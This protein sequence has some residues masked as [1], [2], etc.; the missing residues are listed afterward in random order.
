MSQ[1]SCNA[2]NE[3]REYAPEF[4]VNG[5]T[6]AVCTHLANNKGLSNAD[7]HNDCDDLHDVNDCLIGN[8]A[9][10]LDAFDV[11]D[12]KDFLHQYI[13]NDY[14]TNKALICA[15]CGAWEMIESAWDKIDCLVKA[16]NS[17]VAGRSFSFDSNYVRFP[18]GV[19]AGSDPPFGFAGNAFCAY[20]TGGMMF[21]SNFYDTWLT[22][23]GDIPSG[24]GIL[25][26]E[27]RIPLCDSHGI[28]YVYPGNMQENDNG[29]GVHVHLY[30]YTAGET[31]RGD[32][33]PAIGG[34]GSSVVPDGYEYVQ[35]R[36]HGYRSMG[37]KGT[38]VTCSGVVPV[39][40]CPQNFSC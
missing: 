31:T 40:M 14:E 12:L 39:R 30:T 27:W 34:P 18:S 37:N 33:N 16:M 3:L 23:E 24:G 32:T 9:D 29:S 5:V 35:A 1:K 8:M 25:L 26:Y 10:E 13:P 15:L 4:V 2:C 21:S 11:C 20:L 22:D 38:K 36:L 6:D 7:S 28:Q 19:S 17:L